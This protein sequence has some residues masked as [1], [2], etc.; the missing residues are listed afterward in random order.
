M[1]ICKLGSVLPR[2]VLLC[3]PTEWSLLSL[4]CQEVIETSLSSASLLA[5]DVDL[6]SFP[7]DTFGKGL[8]KKCRTSPDA[9][10]QLALQLAHYRVR[11]DL[12]SSWALGV[13]THTYLGCFPSG[14][15]RYKAQNEE[16][17]TPNTSTS[18][19]GL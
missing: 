6:H 7:F 9:F 14:Q 16:H 19:L 10:I 5:N 13:L 11:E 3:F 8:I 12:S 15:R 1:H 17:L 18:R 4:Q 2:P